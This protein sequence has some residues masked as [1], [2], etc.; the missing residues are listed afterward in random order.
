VGEAVYLADRIIVLCGSPSGVVADIPV[1][2]PRPRDQVTT[3]A[4]PEFVE[5]RTRLLT[6]ID[7]P[8]TDAEH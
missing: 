8:G 4:L 1:E 7:A 2:L 5:L 3:R 6:L